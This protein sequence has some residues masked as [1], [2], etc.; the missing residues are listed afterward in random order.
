MWECDVSRI[1]DRKRGQQE[2]TVHYQQWQAYPEH[3]ANAIQDVCVNGRANGVQFMLY[4]WDPVSDLSHVLTEG[5]VQTV[6]SDHQV[7]EVDVANRTQTNLRTP[8]IRE[9]R[10]VAVT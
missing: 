5:N 4:F 7:Y 8:A 1:D 9:I 10:R 3:I 2:P 6:T